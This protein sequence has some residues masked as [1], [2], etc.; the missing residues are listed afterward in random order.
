MPKVTNS[1]SGQSG[2]VAGEHTVEPGHL[3]RRQDL[4]SKVFVPH[5]VQSPAALRSPYLR[6]PLGRRLVSRPCACR[7]ASPRPC[8]PRSGRGHRRGAPQ[9]RTRTG[10]ARARARACAAPRCA[11]RSSSCPSWRGRHAGEGRPSTAPFTTRPLLSMEKGAST[12][13]GTRRWRSGRMS[14]ALLA[15][16]EGDIERL[17]DQAQHLAGGGLE[18]DVAWLSSCAPS[19]LDC[20]KSPRRAA[21]VLDSLPICRRQCT[22]IREPLML[23]SL[24]GR[25]EL[26]EGRFRVDGPT[27]GLTR[28]DAKECIA[29]PC[30][31]WRNAENTIAL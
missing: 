3:L 12:E 17:S 8:L 20:L 25:L 23:R 13:T 31:K 26:G 30:R 6:R 29:R 10:C 28:E 21:C 19:Q 16:A 9:G 5:L 1:Q 22:F 4:S 2:L 11:C 18:D 7:R 14:A 15:T 27:D 24:E